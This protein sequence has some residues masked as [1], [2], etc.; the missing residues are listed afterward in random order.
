[1][2]LY[3]VFYYAPYNDYGVIGMF[4]KPIY[5][6]SKIEAEYKFMVIIKPPDYRLRIKEIRQ[7]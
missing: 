6:E 1:M 2:N 5:A 4:Y 7:I 3:L